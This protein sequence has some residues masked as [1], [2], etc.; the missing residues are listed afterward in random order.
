MREQDPKTDL[1]VPIPSDPQKIDP[2]TVHTHYFGFSVPEAALGGF[3]Y[4]RWQPAFPLSQG[5]VCIFRGMDNIEFLDLDYLDWQ[6]TMRWPQIDGATITTGTGLSVEFIEPG[7]VVRLRYDSP[8]ASLDL[9]Q[10]AITPLLARSHVVPG[11]EEHADLALLPGGS[12]QY[13]RCVGKLSVNGESFDVD[14]LA[15]RDRSWNQVRTERHGAVEM[16]PVAWT[17]MAFG[18]DLTFNQIGWED[19]ETDPPFMKVYAVDPKRPSHSYGWVRDNGRTTGLARVRREVHE[20]HPITHV[21][22]RQTI[23]A[24]DDEGRVYVFRGQAIASAEVPAWPN[25]ALH[26]SLYR[27]EDERGR[28]SHATCQE[29]WLDKYQRLMNEMSGS[30]TGRP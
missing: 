3:L 29:A 21:A 11:E 19:P 22:T 25:L 2:H 17:P 12:E 8:D 7:R 5:G 10:T 18:E 20:R 30:K 24:E 6:N 26:D 9:V 4:I 13:M 14:C 16:P 15:P 27:W 1:W 23:E 28:V